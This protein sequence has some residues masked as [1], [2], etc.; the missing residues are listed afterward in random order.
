MGTDITDRLAGAPSVL[1]MRDAADAIR[2]L[3]LACV[4]AAD[5][6][7]ASY[8]ALPRDKFPGPPELIIDRLRKAAAVTA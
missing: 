3:R 2:R 6:L 4:V 1:A 7:E 8:M 5:M